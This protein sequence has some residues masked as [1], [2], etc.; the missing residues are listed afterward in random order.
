MA[1]A[2]LSQTCCDSSAVGT[3]TGNCCSRCRL[4]RASSV[5]SIGAQNGPPG[6][7]GG[8]EITGG[9]GALG[10]EALCSGLY[11]GLAIGLEGNYTHAVGSCKHQ[12]P[13][14]NGCQFSVCCRLASRSSHPLHS[15]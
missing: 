4:A 14:R 8:F 2:W 9:T 3:T 5:S 11:S 13:I 7:A 10:S 15:I 6:R 12:V 1:S